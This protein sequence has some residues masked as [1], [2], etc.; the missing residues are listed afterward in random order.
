M[1]AV[2]QAGSV[3]SQATKRARRLAEAMTSVASAWAASK[4]R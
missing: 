1:L 2:T 3:S 4:V